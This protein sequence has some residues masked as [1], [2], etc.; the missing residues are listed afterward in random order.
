VKFLLEHVWSHCT[1]PLVEPADFYARPSW[2][3]DLGD[4]LLTHGQVAQRW[5]TRT[6]RLETWA[7][8]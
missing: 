3:L 7:E 4:E 1:V 2:D 5:V 8:R 6:A